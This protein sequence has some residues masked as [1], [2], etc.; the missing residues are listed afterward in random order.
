[1]INYITAIKGKELKNHENDHDGLDK[2][3][4]RHLPTKQGHNY[5]PIYQRHFE[6]VRF[7]VKKVLEIGVEAGTSLRMWEEYFPNADIYGLDI[8]EACKAAEKGRIKVIIGD[9]CSESDLSKLPDDF[10][11]IIDDGLHTISS[12]IFCFDYLFKNK[13]AER[14]IYVVED[15]IGATKVFDYFNNIAKLNNYWPK[16]EGGEI[17]SSLND[18][19]LYLEKDSRFNEKEI[20][21]IKNVLGVSIYRHLIFVDKGKNPEDGQAAFRLLSK[22]KWGQVGKI[23]GDFIH[24]TDFTPTSKKL[25]TKNPL[26][27]FL[28]KLK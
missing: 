5:L 28:Q 20:Y 15:V 24:N 4:D 10:D 26:K 14:G 11:I 12:Q 13:L 7:D 6:T 2:I 25:S 23:R 21:Y 8:E 3:F 17:W 16:N 1:M 9:Q 27:I 19:G 22:K 18:L